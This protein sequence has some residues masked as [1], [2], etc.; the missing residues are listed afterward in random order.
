M[1]PLKTQK[2]AKNE[3]KGKA[4]AK[5]TADDDILSLIQNASKLED[6][7]SEF[8]DDGNRVPFIKVISKE[9][10]P[11]LNAD[12]E[13][14][15]KGAKFKDFV[16]PKTGT[17]LGQSFSCTIL[18][19]FKMYE[20]KVEPENKKVLPKIVGYWMPDQAKELPMVKGSFF[21]RCY[22]DAD[23]KAHKVSPVFWLYCLINGKLD[24]GLHMM[25]FRATANENIKKVQKLLKELGGITPQHVLKVISE[26]KDFPDFN[27]ATFRPLFQETDKVNFE[28]DSKGKLVAREMDKDE[29]TMT[30]KLYNQLQ[31]DYAHGKLVA[32]KEISE[33]VH[34]LPAPDE[35]LNF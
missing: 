18:G 16:I 29:A 26:R 28:V 1:K 14:Y 11:E 22:L 17:L 34:A 31:T 25:I 23:D 35:D 21:D 3:Q 20:D 24:L 5:T 33:T 4:V 15:I 13:G 10:S 19:I 27:S 12:S 9:T 2:P 6:E 30:I 32:K 7:N 8:L